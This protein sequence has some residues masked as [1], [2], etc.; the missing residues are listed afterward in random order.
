MSDSSG[1]QCVCTQIIT[2]MSKCGLWCVVV[3]NNVDY[4]SNGVGIE[5]GL[6]GVRM[7]RVS[8]PLL[9]SI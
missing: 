8:K 6:S 7:G 2:N 5:G 9:A 3:F 4:N 1:W